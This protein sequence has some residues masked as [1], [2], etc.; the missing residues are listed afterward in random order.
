MRIF[1]MA[2]WNVWLFYWNKFQISEVMVWGPFLHNV[3]N[4]T[5]FSCAKWDC[6]TVHSVLGSLHPPRILVRHKSD[7]RTQTGLCALQSFSRFTYLPCYSW[8]ICF[9]GLWWCP[10]LRDMCWGEGEHIMTFLCQLHLLSSPDPWAIV[11]Y[12]ICAITTVSSRTQLWETNKWADLEKKCLYSEGP[13]GFKG[14]YI[15]G[16]LAVLKARLQLKLC[17]FFF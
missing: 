1:C 15:G 3:Q 13:R 5:L 11:N 7:A 16:W 9:Q 8:H 14:H 6:V 4:M 17:W 2:V 12:P 10:E